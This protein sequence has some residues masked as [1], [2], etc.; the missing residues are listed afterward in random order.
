MAGNPLRVPITNLYGGGDYTAEIRLGAS[1]QTANVILD[2]GSSTLAVVPK[3]Y[4][5][6]GDTERQPTGFAQDVLYGTG[7]WTGPVVQTKLG[8][9]TGNAAVSIDAYVAVAV[10][11]EP[12]GFGRADGIMG[13]A[14]NVLNSAYD[15]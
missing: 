13:L 6:A 15:L 2:T 12:R 1:Q 9:G 11:D 14:Y 4:D 8:L 5:A 10:D 7:G 3:A